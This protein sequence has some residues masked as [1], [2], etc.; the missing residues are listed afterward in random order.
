MVTLYERGKFRTMPASQA[1]EQYG[2]I[3]TPETLAACKQV[4]PKAHCDL[5]PW[6]RAGDVYCRG[7]PVGPTLPHPAEACGCTCSDAYI[8]AYDAWSKRQRACQN[9]P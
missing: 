5:A 8:Q 7:T 1:I 6:Y 4:N 3:G 9:V 2:C